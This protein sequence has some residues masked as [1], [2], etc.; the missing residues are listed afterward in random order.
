LGTNN[1]IQI[2]ENKIFTI[3]GQLVMFDE[4]LA[5][6]Y[7]VKTFRLNEQVKRNPKRFP[8]RYCFQLTD[9]EWES[10]RSQNAMSNDKRG[11]RRY[12]PFVFTEHGCL[13]ASNVLKSDIATEMS[14]FIIDAF[15]TMKNQVQSHPNY[16]LLNERIKR[17]EAE[18]KLFNAKA[19]TIHAEMVALKAE[20]KVDL[21][22]QN[23]EIEDVNEKMTELLHLFNQFRDTHIVIKKDAGI[24]RG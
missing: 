1:Q 23:M 15:V 5:K 12:L 17:L 8:Q 11:G 10:L 13:Q 22:V 21:N 7:E 14:L 6:I 19:E 18:T 3:R 4:D 24:G 9:Q 2:I 16:E 20:H